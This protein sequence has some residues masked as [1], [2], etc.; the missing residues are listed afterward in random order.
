MLAYVEGGPLDFWLCVRPRTFPASLAYNSLHFMMSAC[1]AFAVEAMLERVGG[2][3]EKA[4]CLRLEMSGARAN[5]TLACRH[6]SRHAAC[7]TRKEASNL[8]TDAESRPL[9]DE[10][11]D[12]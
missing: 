2:P 3:K 8:H 4:S 1:R 7:S 9:P 12:L 6:R 11:F 5:R 10:S